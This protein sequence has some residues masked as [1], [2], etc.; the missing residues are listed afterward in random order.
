MQNLLTSV[1]NLEFGPYG[2][3]KNLPLPIYQNNCLISKNQQLTVFEFAL[4]ERKNAFTIEIVNTHKFLS[5][6]SVIGNTV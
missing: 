5:V 3:T 2:R 4:G 6:K 1:A